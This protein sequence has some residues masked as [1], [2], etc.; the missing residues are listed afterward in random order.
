MEEDGTLTDKDGNLMMNGNDYI[1]LF[2]ENDSFVIRSYDDDG[3]QVDIPSSVGANGIFKLKH[4]QTAIF[5][6]FISCQISLLSSKYFF[7]RFVS[8]PFF[9]NE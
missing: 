2:K 9:N 6:K 5:D 7:I 4:G 8:Y 3:A 1:S